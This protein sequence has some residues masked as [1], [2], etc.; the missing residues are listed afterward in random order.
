[1]SDAW[2]WTTKT[3]LASRRN[4]HIDLMEEVLE[5]LKQ[6]GWDGR[7]LF[8]VQMALEES[9]TNAIRH[10]NNCDESKHVDV[11]VRL[12]ADRFWVQVTDEGDGFTPS[13]VADCT[14]EEG[15]AATGGRGM[16]L[17]NAYMTTVE[18]NERG[19]RLT[20]EKVRGESA[21]DAVA[22]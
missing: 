21:D 9:L 4:G 2:N 1:M 16:M 18:H 19:N 22:G 17:I 8:G 3:R 10:G 5:R 20:L 15:L 13:S 11:D 7:D 14:S 12:N 6:L